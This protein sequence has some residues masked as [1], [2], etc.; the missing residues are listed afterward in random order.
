MS[1]QSDIHTLFENIRFLRHK[2]SLSE[3]EMAHRL[4]LDIN[5]LR[6]LEQD[7]LSDDVDIGLLW[8]LSDEFHLPPWAFFTPL[9]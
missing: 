6:L 7:I 3:E 2:H 9:W 4:K 1:V 8:I 5:I